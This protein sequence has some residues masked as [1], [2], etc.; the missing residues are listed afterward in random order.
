[1][2]PQISERRFEDVI[3]CALL[4]GGPDACPDD[5]QVVREVAPPD[6]PEWTPGGY[7]RRTPEEYD[8]ELCLIP[9]DVLDFV[10]ATQ[11]K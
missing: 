5:G 9:G 6:G 7:R 11:P 1:M 3:E 2:S 10:Y 4:A 8:R